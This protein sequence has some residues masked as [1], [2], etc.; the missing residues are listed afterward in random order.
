MSAVLAAALVLAPQNLPGVKY[1]T[2]DYFNTPPYTV[3]LT[4]EKWD[5]HEWSGLTRQQCFFYR[6]ANYV[7][8]N[9]NPNQTALTVTIGSAAISFISPKKVYWHQDLDYFPETGTTTDLSSFRRIY[10]DCDQFPDIAEM[11]VYDS[12]GRGRTVSWS[13]HP[14]GIYFPCGGGSVDW[15]K[16][17]HVQFRLDFNAVPN[18][19][20]FNIARIYAL[21][22]AVPL[23]PP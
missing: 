12:A 20:S 6:R 8:I 3:V 18:P 7:Q 23:A 1:L 19:L 4:G 21:L 2:L 9:S 14:T 16:V 15:K 17:R 22:K 10:L 5:L 13:L 11:S